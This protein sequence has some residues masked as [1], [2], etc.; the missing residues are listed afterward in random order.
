MKSESEEKYLVFLA[1]INWEN[2]KVYYIENEKN[3]KCFEKKLLKLVKEFMERNMSEILNGLNKNE[4]GMKYEE[5]I[6]KL[7]FTPRALKYQLR[8]LY[9]K[10]YISYDENKG[11]YKI[12]K[13]GK[14]YLQRM[15]GKI[16]G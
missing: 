9:K 15:K 13:R 16:L 7:N 10:G 1:P 14:N 2:V 12:T 4:D 3:W 5:L 11:V 8:K 6:D